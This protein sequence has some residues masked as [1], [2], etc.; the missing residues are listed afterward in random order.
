MYLVPPR[1]LR[2]D[3]SPNPE[4]QPYTRSVGSGWVMEVIRD[5]RV[6][7]SRCRY[8]EYESPLT[9]TTM[10]K[11]VKA[12]I[13]GHVARPTTTSS[14]RL[15][16]PRR[17]MDAREDAKATER[18]IPTKFEKRE[19]FLENL[20]LLLSLDLNQDPPDE[21]SRSEWLRLHYLELTV[22]DR[23]PVEI[24]LILMVGLPLICLDKNLPRAALS[25]G[26]IPRRNGT[27]NRRDPQKSR[28]SSRRRRSGGC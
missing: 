20:H 6:K 5:R 4:S 27:S 13:H 17:V 26:S 7:K 23:T 9:M 11:V 14:R 22:S 24:G 19:W 2:V 10:V 8:C 15:S 12:S 25:F 18:A 3:K 21:D 16:A 28:Q 1:E